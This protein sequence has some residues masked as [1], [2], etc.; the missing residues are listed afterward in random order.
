MGPYIAPRIAPKIGP[1]PAIFK[2]CMTNILHG[3]RG[4]KSTPSL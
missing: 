2:N 3:F 4:K 1:R